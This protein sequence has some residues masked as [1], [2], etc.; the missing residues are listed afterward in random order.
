MSVNEVDF[1]VP[2]YET[3]R[4]LSGLEL[5]KRVC[6]GQLPQAPIAEILGFRMIEAEEGLAVF[7]GILD[8]H[9]KFLVHGTTTC[10][11]MPLP[12]AAA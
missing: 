9:G 5:L 6:A 2:S 4:S 11:I 1:G 8:R 12:E 7:H 3:L 10:T